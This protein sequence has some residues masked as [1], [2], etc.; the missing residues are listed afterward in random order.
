MLTVSRLRYLLSYNKST[1]IMRW[2][3]PTSNR[4]RVGSVAGCS[5]ADGFR[6]IAIDGRSYLTNRLAV[7]HQTGEWPASN[8]IFKNGNRSDVSWR[9]LRTA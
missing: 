9:N 1:G 4:V 8:V 2:K 7:L 3:N 5:R 6:K